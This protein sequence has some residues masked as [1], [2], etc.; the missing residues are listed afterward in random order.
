MR[1]SIL[2]FMWTTTVLEFGKKIKK[3]QFRIERLIESKLLRV[4]PLRVSVS[5][6][7]L[8]SFPQGERR[9]RVLV[10]HTGRSVNAGAGQIL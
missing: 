6:C 7:V 9:T 3:I 8:T 10:N 1:A 5:G 4:F 2:I